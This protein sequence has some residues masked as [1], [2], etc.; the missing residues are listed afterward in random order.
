MAIAYFPNMY[1]DELVYSVLSRFYVHCGYPTYT[2]AV[3]DLLGNAKCKVEKE[4]VKN[5]KPEIVDLLTRNMS[6]SE[7]LEQHT[8][9]PMYGRFIDSERRENA[10]HVL[11]NLEGDFS[12]LFGIPNL[13]KGEQRFLR[14]CP[15]CVQEDR[16]ICGE[17]YWHRIH[18]IKGME[19]CSH[20]KCYLKNSTVILDSRGNVW[21]VSAE[22]VITDNDILQK[23][24]QFCDNQSELELT[25]YIAA[26]FQSPL[27]MRKSVPIGK[28]LHY[29]M[30]GTPYLGAR[31]EHIYFNRLW[32][33]LKEHFNGIPGM[34][35]FTGNH[36]HTIIKGDRFVFWEICMMAMFLKISVD[37]LVTAKENIKMPQQIF[38]E[39][40]YRLW[41]QG[42]GI[43]E[44][45]RKLGVASSLVRMAIGITERKPKATAQKIFKSRKQDR[46]T[47]DKETLPLVKQ[48]ISELHGTGEQRPCRISMGAVSK[49]IKVSRYLLQDL[50][51]CKQVIEKAIECDDKY[52]ARKVIW[53]VNVLQKSEKS[54][55]LWRLRYLC[56]LEKEDMIACLPYLEQMA[57]PDIVD[58]VK[59]KL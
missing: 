37:E 16:E 28:F 42:L 43:N 21:L 14:Y 55:K 51:L 29:R 19:V 10:Y 3:Q 50:E 41:K 33:D 2:Y 8:M 54:I 59:S 35:D 1:P 24:I 39:R 45:A 52:H 4:F 18:Q 11:M 48:A 49:K 17:T 40:V 44:I 38:D 36:V 23:N 57:T 53:A 26:V 6:F 56:K 12:K 30:M 27:D 58:I 47:L 20:H 46:V 32:A 25:M 15:L 9:L 22:E 7:L 31:G 34:D 13:K 5:I